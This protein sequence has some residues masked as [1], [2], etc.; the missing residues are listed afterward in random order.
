MAGGGAYAERVR[1]VIGVVRLLLRGVLNTPHKWTTG[2]SK[3]VDKTFGV[4]DVRAIYVVHGRRSTHYMVRTVI[5]II[6]YS[7]VD[8]F[9][10][11]HSIV[12][13]VRYRLVPGDGFGLCKASHTTL[14]VRRADGY[15]FGVRAFRSDLAAIR[16][17]QPFRS[18]KSES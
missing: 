6:T 15:A 17:S 18:Y 7:A 1:Y 16:M 4:N 10:F 2:I 8:F 14:N 5:V 13:S 12:R 3:K 11:Y 9:R